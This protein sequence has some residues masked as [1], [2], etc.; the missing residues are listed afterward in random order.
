MKLVTAFALLFF[1]VSVA[2]ARLTEKENE[3][4]ARFGKVEMRTPEK[5]SIQGRTYEVGTN[6]HFRSEQWSIVAL[7]IDDRCARITYRKVG[8]WTEE[9]IA[10]LLDRNG[11]AATYKEEKREIGESYRTW[12]Q[13][14][15]VTAV[16]LLGSLRI[17]HP[18]YE[19]RLA[20]LKSSAEAESKR[21]PKF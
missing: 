9:Q 12:K 20:V 3:L 6:L 19:R 13:I 11:G 10:G 17:T 5:T 15:G 2:H 1:F 8:D 4:I 18:L 7:L 16:F 14:N 21:P